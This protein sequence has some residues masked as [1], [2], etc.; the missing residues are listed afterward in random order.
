MEPKVSTDNRLDEIDAE[1]LRLMMGSKPFA[2]L[3][4]RMR[5]EAERAS[6]A[7]A[8]ETELP[9]IYRA[10]GALSAYA[11][12]LAMPQTILNEIAAKKLT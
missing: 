8:R 1:Q 2:L 9:T 11:V 3:M 4:K 7:V 10:Q 12:V 6:L 5:A